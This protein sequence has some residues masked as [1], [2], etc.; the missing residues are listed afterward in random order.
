MRH[1]V[2]KFMASAHNCAAGW[3][4]GRADVKIGEAS[5][6]CVEFIQIGCAENFITHTREISESLIVSHHQD[7]IGTTTFERFIGG[8]CGHVC[9]NEEGGNERYI[10]HEVFFYCTWI[11]GSCYTHF[12]E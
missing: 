4:T 6:D 2:S 12:K 11:V 10:F 3:C 8:G 7:D 1:P 9:E 5:R